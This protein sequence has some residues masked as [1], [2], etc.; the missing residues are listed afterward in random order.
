M[1]LRRVHALARF[2]SPGPAAWCWL[3]VQPGEPHRIDR[4]RVDL[5]RG[6]FKYAYLGKILS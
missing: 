4:R 2:I 3:E 5:L 6:V 1:R